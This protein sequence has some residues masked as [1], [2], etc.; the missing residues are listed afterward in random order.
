MKVC[1]GCTA[2]VPEDANFC[3]ECGT[4]VAVRVCP[5]CG[6][7]AA[8]GRFC[9]RCGTAIDDAAPQE[10]DPSAG[11]V[12]ERRMTSVLFGDLVGFTTLSEKRD[13]EE[14]RELMSRYF[15]QCRVII[16]RYGGTVEKFIGDAVMAVWGVPVAHEDDAERA[17]RAGLELVSAIAV[18]GSELGADDLAIRVGIV[19]GEVAVTVGATQE[20]MVTGDSVNTAARVQSAA[21]PGQVWVDDRTR[22]LASASVTFTDAGSHELKGKAEAVHLWRAGRVVAELGGQRRVDGLE[23]PLAGRAADLRLVKD[24]FHATHES[25]RPRLVVLE[26]EAGI[27]KSRLAWEFEKYVDALS[28]NA[29]W[30]RGRCLS[31]GDGVAFWALSEAMRARFGLVEADS[32]ATVI[33]HLDRGLERMVADADER[34]WLRPRL[35]VLLGAGGATSFAREDLFAAWTT[36][37]EILGRDGNSVVFVLDDAQHADDGLLDFLDH[38]LA[39]A[40]APIFVLTLARPELMARRPALGGRRTTVV[41]LEPL[42][43]DQMSTLLDG[44]VDGLQ[45][46]TRA[47]LVERAEGVPLFAVETVR[48]LIDRD[49]VVPHEGRYVAQ[50]GV[51]AGL[52]VIGA[53]ASLQALVAAR[54]DALSP[55]EKQVVTAAS[56]LGATFHGEGLVALGVDPQALDGALE[57]LQRK[58][59]LVLS[60]DR[61]STERGQFKFVQTVVRQV[62]YGTQSRRDRKA[63]HLG[64]AAYLESLPDPSDDLAVLVAQHLLDAADA[65]LPADDDVVDLVSRACDLLARGAARAKALGA[66]GEAQRLIETAL[67]RIEEPSVRAR[68]HL[69]AAVV[70]GDASHHVDSEHHAERAEQLYLELDDRV[71]AATAAAARAG[72]LYSQGNRAA[73]FSVAEAHWAALEDEPGIEPALLQLATQLSRT[74]ERLGKHVERAFYTDRMLRLAEAVGDRGAL[75]RA[76]IQVGTAYLFNGAPLSARASYET[77]VTLAREYGGEALPTALSNLS[78]IMNSRGLAAA[79]AHALDA[80][81]S[82]RRAGQKTYVDFGMFNL[83]IGRWLSGNLDDAVAL[84]AE[85]EESVIDPAIVPCLPTV[86][87]WLAVAR[88]TDL[89]E[90]PDLSPDDSDD[91][92]LHAWLLSGSL[93]RARAMGDTQ[94]AR[95]LAR[96]VLEAQMFES[97]I[98]EDFGVLWPDTVLAALAA[99]D[100]GL[101]RELIAPVL[102]TAPALVPPLVQANIHRFEAL[103][104]AADGV[105]LDRVEERLRQAVDLL[106]EFGA[107]SMRAQTQEDLGRWLVS[108]E[109][110]SDAKPE[111]ASAESTYSRI[112]AAGWLATLQSWTRENLPV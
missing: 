4:P 60:T 55:A 50:P 41:R 18:L 20:G 13:A 99:D 28:D 11:P 49:L 9:G 88:G 73:A 76:H 94:L 35:A 102:S 74:S 67:D 97:A 40:R 30:H 91:H 51:D 111:L 66:P 6:T 56:V 25:R 103:I 90:L 71:S 47:A 54:L 98:E 105:A 108:Q 36:F 63:R 26:S 45:P 75:A 70:A 104:D 62:A 78:G 27:G 8:R 39:T 21:E 109:R 38:L 65:S 37:L 1:Q 44:L 61:F 23:A 58:E 16:G 14:M 81:E 57:S 106:E 12:A 80:V 69:M 29:W 15:A 31:Y 96:G 59:I 107:V 19:T 93:A 5:S 68:L 7:L 84:C 48:A 101:A 77:A 100:T 17:V 79:Q 3:L 52:E 89:P 95:S 32:G 87:T 46:Q 82:A 83:L 43:D 64:A 53:P 112:G 10:P 86:A 34:D 33:E 42:D 85:A 2:D 92:G 72:A 22:S 24:L 110:Y